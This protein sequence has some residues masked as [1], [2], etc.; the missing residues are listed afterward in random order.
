[1]T[2]P[3]LQLSKG[4]ANKS[5]LMQKV[6]I[7]REERIIKLRRINHWWNISLTVVGIVFT[8]SAGFMGFVDSNDK[9]TQ[10]LAKIAIGFFSVSAVA[11]QTA[12]TEFRVRS[13][14]AIYALISADAEVLEDKIQYAEDNELPQLRE[15]YYDLIQKA[16]KAE[17]EFNKEQ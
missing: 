9:N 7:F 11:V 17:A 1:M 14:A 8:L 13:K 3:N 10:N 5:E 2:N 15:K 6:K 4:I 12:N 16:A